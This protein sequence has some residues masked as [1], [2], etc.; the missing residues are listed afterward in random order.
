M[1]QT[2]WMKATMSLVLVL[3][4]GLAAMPTEAQPS[5]AQVQRVIFAS[6]GFDETNRF[7]RNRFEL[8]YATRLNRAAGLYVGW[9]L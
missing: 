2:T 7:E 9:R 1:K 5:E 6:A 8:S 3:L 4:M